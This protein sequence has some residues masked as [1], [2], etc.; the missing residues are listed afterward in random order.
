MLGERDGFTLV[1]L[2]AVVAIIV[3][4]TAIVVPNITGR[5]TVARMHAAEDQI[6]EIEAALAAY[7][8][9]FGAYPGDV[10]PTEDINNNGRLD[11][12]EDIGVDVDRN[13][14]ADYGS[15]NNR[16]D[17]GDGLVNIYD[18]EWALATT[19]KNGPYMDA[20]PLDPWDN[21]YVYC[22]PLE[23]P[24]DSSH[25][26]YLNPASMTSEDD[27]QN[28]R[29][30][31]TEDDGIALYANIA[32]IRCG[33]GNN[34]LDYGD[35]DNKDG[36]IYTYLTVQAAPAPQQ[37][38]QL[39][40]GNKDISPDGLARNMGYYIYS[41]GRNSRD[42]SATGYE[43]INLNSQLDN[44]LY[45]DTGNEKEDTNTTT[46]PLGDND[47]SLDTGYEDT[48]IDGIP[49][50]KDLGEDNWE[51]NN[52]PDASGG[53][54]EDFSGPYNTTDQ[55]DIG[56]DDINNWNKSRPWRKHVSYGGDY[57]EE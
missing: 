53:K 27:N 12:G 31:E 24:T 39:E 20:I 51:T 13:G 19:A 55:L 7:H 40:L 3:L 41:V 26:L 35:D 37:A 57:G 10:F 28:G 47:N 6:A 2:L 44:P 50:T 14:T 45:N 29:L 49:R 23:R 11:T 21:K 1:E 9:D 5:I 16:L 8:A 22:T 32:G 18:L 15:G 48:G 42:Q 30:D 56:G 54:N 4:L 38:D 36:R 34:I 52:E 43:D 46:P 33:S 17:R 25:P